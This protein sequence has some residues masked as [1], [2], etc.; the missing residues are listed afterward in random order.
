MFWW[1]GSGTRSAAPRTSSKHLGVGERLVALALGDDY[2]NDHE[3]TNSSIKSKRWLREPATPRQLEVL[4]LP[5]FDTATTKYQA[6]CM[7]GFRMNKKG[8]L[9]IVRSTDNERA[10]A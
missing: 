4:G 1:K 3:D 7:L 2:L 10:A 8:I 9:H 5:S 6:A